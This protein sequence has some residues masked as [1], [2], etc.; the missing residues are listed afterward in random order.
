VKLRV[1]VDQRMLPTPS[2][3]VLCAALAAPV[4]GDVVLDVAVSGRSVVRRRW[5]PLPRSAFTSCAAI[6]RDIA[7]LLRQLGV[8]DAT[9]PPKA[10]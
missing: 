6:D 8:E 5:P 9:R 2:D 3:V 1:T 10:P 4:G 7:E